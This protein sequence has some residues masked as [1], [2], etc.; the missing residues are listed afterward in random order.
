VSSLGF[1]LQQVNGT[2][3][4]VTSTAP[5]DGKSATALNIAIAAAQDGRHPLLIDADERARGLTRLA[6]AN[7]QP[8]ITDLGNGTATTDV[9]GSWGMIDGT[10]LPFV[11]AGTELDGSTAGYFRSASFKTAL[12]S[13]ASD[14]DIVIIDA[15]PIMSAAETTDLAAEADGVILVVRQGAPLS[16]LDD[17]RQRIS[18]SGTP[19]LGYVFNRAKGKSGGYGYGYGY[20]RTND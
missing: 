1:A 9:V 16:D 2:S 7:G 10:K 5:G 18:M 8:G 4:V 17:A 19:I 6:G 12:A 13:L 11:A 3:V 15:P 14:R 20:G